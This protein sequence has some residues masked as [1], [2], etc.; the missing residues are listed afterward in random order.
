MALEAS[1]RHR[2]RDAF[3]VYLEAA[4][5]LISPYRRTLKALRARW[6]RICEKD[7]WLASRYF[8][9]THAL[10]PER[11]VDDRTWGDLEFPRIF[12]IL[13][14]TVTPLGSQA[15]Y[16]QLRSYPEHPDATA[17]GYRTAVLLRSGQLLRE[18][19]QLRLASLRADSYAR[20]ADTL[21][22]AAPRRLPMSA[23]IVVWSIL[24]AL[25]L[26][27]AAYTV[28]SA[29]APSWPLLL[30][31][32]VL[33]A[34]VAIIYWIASG[35]ERI[36]SLKRCHDLVRVAEALARVP[37]GNA[38]PELAELAASRAE[39]ARARR[40]FRPLALLERLPLGTGT[41]L[42]LLFLAELVAYIRI[43]RTFPALGPQ[44]RRAFALVASLD[45]TIAVASLLERSPAHCVPT[46]VNGRVIEIDAGCH[47]LLARQTANSV[48]LHDRS[49][50]VTGSNMAGK[51]TFIKMI[52]IN[53][54]L[55]RTLGLCLAARAV[56]PAAGVMA[57]IR[58]EHSTESGKSRYFAELE[59]VL[60]F[61]RRAEERA[62]LV[63]V[64]D[65][66][67]SGTNTLERIAAAKAVLEALARHAQVLAT[68]HD[69]EL[70]EL[71]D[72][73]FANFHFTENPDLEG[74]FDYRLRPGGCT[75]GNA[76]RLLE[77]IGFPPA[78]VTEARR[79]AAE[80]SRAGRERSPADAVSDATRPPAD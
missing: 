70:G 33:I 6:G 11:C 4:L 56:I 71:L 66:P 79:I 78:V 77:K 65:E 30:E 45:A 52:G 80:T 40:A 47:P 9:L 51:T 25:L 18:A 37:A 15:L 75:E 26:L 21:F 12:A 63:F 49:A 14:T 17:V 46:L 67:F 36:Q 54:I 29:S 50:L 32:P 2:T 13:D 23:L 38:V 58:A 3:R 31:L 57:C 8:E 55:G 28:W 34:N 60:A 64:L 19:I 27:G 20:L 42:N 41:W 39:L 7:A 24:C 73:R 44:L 1:R 5:E 16:R 48:T 10:E 72:E 59:A 62:A 61:L 53:I 74:F 76:L 43:A 35:Y 68:T 69:V 22:G